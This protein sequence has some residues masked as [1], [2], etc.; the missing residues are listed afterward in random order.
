MRASRFVICVAAV[1]AGGALAA[2]SS[3]SGE[4]AVFSLPQA[5]AT[6]SSPVR[7]GVEGEGIARAVFA[8]DGKTW[9]QIETPPFETDLDPSSYPPGDAMLTVTAVFADGAQSVR[10]VA[11]VFPA[12][13]SPVALTVEGGTGDGSYLPGTRVAIEADPPPTDSVFDRWTGDVAGVESVTSA[14]TFV[15]VPNGGA[16]VRSTYR[17]AGTPGTVQATVETDPVPGGGDAADDPCI[18]IHPTDPALSTVIGTDKSGFYLLVYDLDGNELQRVST[19]KMNNVDL[20]YNFP[21]GGTNVALVTATNRS[22]DTIEAYRVN[23]ATRQ[24]EAAGSFAAG[25][26]VYG[27]CMYV[28]PVNGDT[29]VFVNSSGGG[30]EQWR[31]TGSGGSVTG[32]RVRS[33]SVGSIVEG[34][35]AD[36]ELGHFYVAEETRGIWKYGAEP[37][38]GTTRTLVDGT[39]SAGNLAADVEGL[40]IYY[41]AGGTGYLIASSQGDSSYVV[42]ERGGSNAFLMKF[43]VVSGGGIDGTSDTDGI[44]VTNFPLGASFPHGLFVV[45]DGGNDSGNQ[46]FKLVPWESVAAAHVPA[47]LIDTSWDP[48]AVGE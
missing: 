45:Q 44:D 11:I 6:I 15:V 1:L 35:V 32:T 5:G 25:L 34:C 20:R 27:M 10:S 43:R 19:G 24:L 7:V 18:W 47:L 40:A 28:S 22:N 14:S 38:D 8:I 33:F 12:G 23:P 42:Y 37:G 4:S 26:A 16:T 3:G 21:L 29:Y 9:A 41:A 30:V 17:A 39:G 36:D 48:R 31:V 46:N 2:C 13:D